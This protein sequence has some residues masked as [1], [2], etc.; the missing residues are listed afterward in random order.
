MGEVFRRVYVP[1]RIAVT[2]HEWLESL[3][4][5]HGVTKSEVI[6]QSLAVAR[7]HERELVKRLEKT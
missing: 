2:G 4:T 6:R 5:K 7:L 1:F 3:A